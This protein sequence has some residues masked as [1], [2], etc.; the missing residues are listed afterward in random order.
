MDEYSTGFSASEA[1]LTSS[2]RYREAAISVD[3]RVHRQP[4]YPGTMQVVGDVVV[5]LDSGMQPRWVWNSFDHLN[6]NRHPYLFPDWTHANS[7]AYS[8]DDGNFIISLRQQNWV[9]KIDYENGTGTGNILWRLGEGG[10]FAL[11]GAT[12]PTDWFYAQHYAEFTS[13]NTT[14]IFSLELFDNGDDR[15]LRAGTICGPLPRQTPCLYSTVQEVDENAKTAKFLF[16]DILPAKFYS[17]F[18]GNADLLAN[19]NF[20]YNLAGVGTS[21]YVFEVMPGKDI[22]DTPKTIW[23]MDLPGTNTYRALRLPSLYPSVQW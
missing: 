3:H 7:I 2:L 18:A 15:M 12:D 11:Q 19:G 10:D 20:H 23:E 16:H 14:G 13:A 8:K 17:A 21:S 4:G 1:R 9:L 6:I 22:T 5:D